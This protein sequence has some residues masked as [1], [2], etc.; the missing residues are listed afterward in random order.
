[1]TQLPD[2]PDLDQ[3][4]RR[5]KELRRRSPEGTSLAAAQL[6]VARD[7][8]FTS[9][10]RLR[11][12]VESRG[13]AAGGPLAPDKHGAA[14]VHPA[15]EF[16]SSARARGWD[17]GTLPVGAIFTAQTF[18]TSHVEARPDRYRPSETLLPTNGR[19]FMTSTSPPVA[20]A[21]LGVGAPAVVTLLEHLVGLG[22]RSFV[23]VGPAPAVAPGLE[24]GTCVVVDRALR[25]DGV[26]QHYLAPARYARADGALTDRLLAEAQAKGLDPRIGSTWTVPTPYR[27]TAEELAAYREEGVLVTELTTAALFAVA[28]TLG[29][30]AASAVTVTRTLGEPPTALP[31]DRQKGQIFTLLD[32]TVEALLA[33]AA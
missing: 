30:R 27:T 11:E 22:V 33:V 2:R 29:A 1:M 25:D 6:A 14:A 18:L 28:T 20:I 19:I 8:G 16:L 13:K 17:P 9:W 26:S 12:A 31:P 21:C 7:H 15:T 5:A 3:L 32:A 4:R 24:W 23:A 10:P